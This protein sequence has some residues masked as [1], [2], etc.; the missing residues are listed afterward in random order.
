VAR[1]DATGGRVPT[2]LVEAAAW[3]LAIVVDCRRCSHQ[4]V[5]SP[6]ALW[7]LF[8]RRHEDCGFRNVARRMKCSKCGA[9]AFLTWSKD[10]EPTVQLPM[11]SESEWKRAVSRM[12][13]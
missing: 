8:E 6:H 1:Y 12:R 13:G 3:H 7:W 9:G 11:P 2:S 4:A 10:K 5:F